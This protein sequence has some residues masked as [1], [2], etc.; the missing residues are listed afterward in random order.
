MIKNYLIMSF[1][2]NYFIWI[3]ICLIIW[4][5]KNIS[6]HSTIVYSFLV[7]QFNALHLLDFHHTHV[8]FFRYAIKHRNDHIK[9]LLEPFIAVHFYPRYLGLIKR[10]TN[11]LKCSLYFS[12]KFSGLLIK[13]C[14][15][16]LE[17]CDIKKI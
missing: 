11:S 10:S 7:E 4:S 8:S 2:E 14:T 13:Y 3:N 17:R 12:G 15:T 16:K 1:I 9:K 6:F 5:N